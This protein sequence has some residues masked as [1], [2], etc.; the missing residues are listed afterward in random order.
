[1]NIHSN[2]AQNNGPCRDTHAIFQKVIKYFHEKVHGIDPDID[3][4]IDVEFNR[5][6]NLRKSLKEGPS[7]QPAE[8][9]AE[10]DDHNVTFAPK[11]QGLYKKPAKKPDH[12][13]K[14]LPQGQDFHMS[15][16]FD[17]MCFFSQKAYSATKHSNKGEYCDGFAKASLDAHAN[18]N[19]ELAHIYKEQWIREQLKFFQNNGQFWNFCKSVF[20]SGC[21][22]GVLLPVRID[23]VIDDWSLETIQKFCDQCQVGEVGYFW[24]KVSYSLGSGLF[25]RAKKSCSCTCVHFFHSY[26]SF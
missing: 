4:V 16:I 8:T 20:T 18:F 3:H 13:V 22:T 10:T 7:K 15:N 5:L 26:L 17:K 25:M 24:A 2:V 9:P 1:M 14:I 11:E 23:P 12:T 21:D 6:Y 19:Y